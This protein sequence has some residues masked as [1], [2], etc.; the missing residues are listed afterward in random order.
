[1]PEG[2]DPAVAR[3]LREQGW[4]TVA[5]LA[6]AKDKRA[7]AKRLGCGHLLENGKPIALS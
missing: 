5:A 2:A 3:G 4:V 1:V 6:P 7:E